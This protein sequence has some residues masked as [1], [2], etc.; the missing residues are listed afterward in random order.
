VA[1]GVQNRLKNGAS[2]QTGSGEWALVEGHAR[3]ADG[4]LRISS[5]GHRFWPS[6]RQMV[7]Q[8]GLPGRVVAAS[9]RAMQ[10]PDAPLQPMQFAVLKLNFIGARGVPF[11]YASRH[12]QFSGEQVGH[13]QNAQIAAIAPPGTKGVNVELLLNA[14]GKEHGAVIFDDAVLT[15]GEP[16]AHPSSESK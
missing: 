7:R 10:P 9:V 8:T 12:F 1:D 2:D 14:R 5:L 11:A 15:I 16:V 6:A 4:T 3:I 13:F